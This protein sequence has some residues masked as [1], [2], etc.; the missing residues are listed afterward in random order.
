M[1]FF[2][3]MEHR[4]LEEAQPES[5][6][7]DKAVFIKK[8]LLKNCSRS[9][10]VYKAVEK[11]LFSFEGALTKK[12]FEHQMKR[13]DFNDSVALSQLERAMGK[14]RI[15]LP[16]PPKKPPLVKSL[17]EQVLEDKYVAIYGR[18][19][20]K[21]IAEGI[22]QFRTCGD[23]YVLSVEE[24][25]LNFK[26]YEDKGK[27]PQMIDKA[28]QCD[29]LFVVDLEMPITIEW[30]IREAVERIGRKRE[31]AGLPIVSTWCRFNDVNAYFERFKIYYVK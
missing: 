5:P 14:R 3:N 22:K 30:H 27:A 1:Q 13:L 26:S 20:K 19:F 8:N 11:W 29:F 15:P 21:V 6:T 10:E 18:G 25:I 28:I 31:E 17:M 12:V 9:G 7:I 24:L 2:E 16:P 4:T 23:V